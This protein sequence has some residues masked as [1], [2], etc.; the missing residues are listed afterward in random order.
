MCLFS[1]Q[2]VPPDC[3][4]TEPQRDK[5]PI[6]FS[7][8]T[9]PTVVGEE[10]GAGG[11][12][13]EGEAKKKHRKRPNRKGASQSVSKPIRAIDGPPRPNDPMW[14][15]HMMG[16]PM[17][18]KQMLADATGDMRSLH[19]SIMVLEKCILDDTSAGYPTFVAKVPAGKARGLCG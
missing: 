12:C 8:N 17:L 19:D 13:L 6:I 1:S 3:A 10:I 7:P 5:Q 4:F 18:N 15:L 2:E 9:I 16:A 14:R 11:G